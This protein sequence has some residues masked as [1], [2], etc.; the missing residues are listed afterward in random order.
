MWEFY[1]MSV[2]AAALFFFSMWQARRIGYVERAIDSS[3]N[4]IRVLLDNQ[5]R[6]RKEALTKYQDHTQLQLRYTKMENAQY[7]G[8]RKLH[9]TRRRLRI[10]TGERDRLLAQGIHDMDIEVVLDDEDQADAYL[11]SLKAAMEESPKVPGLTGEGTPL[12]PYDLFLFKDIDEDPNA[13]G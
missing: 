1:A 6:E 7:D 3:A 8:A 10:I 2:G 12:E 13:K 5:R 11:A 4:A 9:H